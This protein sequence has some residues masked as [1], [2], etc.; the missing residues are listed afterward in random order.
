M[1]QNLLK[2]GIMIQNLLKIGIMIQNFKK[3]LP[4][5]FSF[6]QI[7]PWTSDQDCTCKMMSFEKFSPQ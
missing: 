5:A 1:I 3:T 7:N 2:I 6:A 4:L